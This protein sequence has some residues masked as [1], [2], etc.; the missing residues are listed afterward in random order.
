M[1]SGIFI[2]NLSE[3]SSTGTVLQSMASG[4]LKYN[5]SEDSSTMYSTA[6]HYYWVDIGTATG[7]IPVQEVVLLNQIIVVDVLLLCQS[8]RWYCYTGS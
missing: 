3:D 1:A 7:A 6:V 4:I 5:L 8:M 2:Y